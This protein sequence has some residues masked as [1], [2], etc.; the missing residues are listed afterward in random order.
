MRRYP[1]SLISDDWTDSFCRSTYALVSLVTEPENI[2]HRP[3]SGLYRLRFWRPGQYVAD[4]QTVTI[5]RNWPSSSFVVV[6]GFWNK[7][8][9]GWVR[10]RATQAVEEGLVSVAHISVQKTPTQ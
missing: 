9:V 3:L 1:A 5:P 10:I 2:G 7:R 8:R 6:M 4:T